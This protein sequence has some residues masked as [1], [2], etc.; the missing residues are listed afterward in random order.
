FVP[1]TGFKDLVTGVIG[2][3]DSHMM[4]YIAGGF[5]AQMIDGALGMAYGVSVTTFLLS[6]G[7]PAITPAIASASM[8]ASEIFTTGSSSLVYMRYKNVNMKL[9]RKILWPGALGAVAGALA[10][11]FVS[12]KY[13]SIVKP[14]I[15]V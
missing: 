6:L 12:K 15:A 13:F 14:V 11:S 2:K 8:H 9:F 5:T 4:L 7:I 3:L 10:I 1:L